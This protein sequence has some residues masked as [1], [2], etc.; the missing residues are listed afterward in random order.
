MIRAKELLLTGL[1][2]KNKIWHDQCTDQSSFMQDKRPHNRW[3]WVVLVPSEGS[4][5]G[6][7]SGSALHSFVFQYLLVARGGC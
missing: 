5:G 7:A 3:V 6:A 1:P 4:L 2:G